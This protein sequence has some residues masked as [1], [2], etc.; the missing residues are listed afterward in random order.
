MLPLV[1]S[2]WGIDSRH[3]RKVPVR[4]MAISRFHSSSVTSWEW[5]NDSTPATLTTTSSEPRVSTAP[6]TMAWTPSSVETSPGRA[7]IEPDSPAASA[8]T[9][10][11]AAALTSTATTAAPS[12]ARRRAV[13]RPMPEAPPV[14]STCFPSN[15]SRVMAAL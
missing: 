11:R 5:P 8:A 6:D 9:P 4:L 3:I 2:R 7:M 12:S 15:R 13:D 14:T 1:A 10:S